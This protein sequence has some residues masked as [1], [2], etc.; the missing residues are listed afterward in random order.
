[1]KLKNILKLS[2]LA[3]S[4]LALSS[5]LKDQEDVFEKGSADRMSDY[6]ADMRAVLKS[7]KYGWRMS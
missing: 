1:M 7:P 6:L 2:A 4:L 5:C 3:F